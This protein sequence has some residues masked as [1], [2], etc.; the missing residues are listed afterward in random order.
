M[1]IADDSDSI[2]YRVRLPHDFGSG[3][4]AEI[5]MLTEPEVREVEID[6][7][8]S[9]AKDAAGIRAHEL[10]HGLIAMLTKI[11][12]GPVGMMTPLTDES[13][14]WIDLNLQTLTT[15]DT[16][17]YKNPNSFEKLFSRFPKDVAALERWYTKLHELTADEVRALEGNA[18]PVSLG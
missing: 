2:V 8:N 4:A 1:T 15:V 6:A 13:I 11:S 16:A 7:A 5:R 9:G 10:R 17:S 3:R 14:K 18:L 12:E